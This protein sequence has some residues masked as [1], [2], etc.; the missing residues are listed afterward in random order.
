MKNEDFL[1]KY[2]EFI[3]DILLEFDKKYNFKSEN[4]ALNYTTKLFNNI[5]KAFR[6]S[7][8]HAFLVERLSDIFYVKNL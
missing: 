5:T 8:L 1:I 7:R 6:Q 4:D 2:C 3:F